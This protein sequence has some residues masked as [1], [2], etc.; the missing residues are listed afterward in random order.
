MTKAHYTAAVPNSLQAKNINIPYP[1]A[2]AA[3]RAAIAH[4]IATG[5]A[6]AY[7]SH[8]VTVKIE[9]NP[10]AAVDPCLGVPKTTCF[11][12]QESKPYCK[13]NCGSRWYNQ[14]NVNPIHY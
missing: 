3:H 2:A 5:N 6:T 10:N 13:N 7:N 8:N 4:Q 14:M 11:G 1:P 12:N 9:M